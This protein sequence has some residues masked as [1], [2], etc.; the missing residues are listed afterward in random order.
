MRKLSVFM[1]TT[2]DGYHTGPNGDIEW[3]TIDDDFN[4]FAARQLDAAD[5]L[6][7]GRVTY[8]LMA[9]YWPTPFAIE[10][11]PATAQRMNHMAKVVFSH[12]LD[13]ADWQNTRLVKGKAAAEIQTLKQQ[14]GKDLLIL[15]SSRL[16]ASLMGQIDELRIMVAPVLLGAGQSAFAGTG[17]QKLKLL[18]SEAFRSGNVLHTYALAQSQTVIL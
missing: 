7:F 13:R 6:I 12:T 1:M 18:K 2:L 10:D 15:G 14:P 17:L 4:G 5:T 9:S 11:D 16:C 3:H 8:E